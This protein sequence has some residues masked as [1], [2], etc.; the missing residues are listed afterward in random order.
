[1]CL[2]TFFNFSAPLLSSIAWGG[3]VFPLSKGE[4]QGQEVGLT[5]G[6]ENCLCDF[7]FLPQLCVLRTLPGAWR[8]PLRRGGGPPGFWQ[9][10]PRWDGASAFSWRVALFPK[11][12]RVFP[13]IPVDVLP[14]FTTVRVWVEKESARSLLI[15][16][17]RL[18]E[19][20]FP[21]LA[22]SLSTSLFRVP[23]PSCAVGSLVDKGQPPFG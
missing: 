12:F 7:T 22:A 20:C 15:P 5:S 9:P 14:Q 19:F 17:H 4:G 13:A 3:R 6:R 1:M 10:R 8:R 23:S 21:W 11:V 18:G 16:E 2:G